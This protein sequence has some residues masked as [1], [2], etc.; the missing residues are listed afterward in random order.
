MGIIITKIR[1]INW[2]SSLNCRICDNTVKIYDCLQLQCGH[3]F[4]R[5]CFRSLMKDENNTNC[6]LCKKNN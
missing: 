2:K 3:L 4:H 1:K 6:P 5:M